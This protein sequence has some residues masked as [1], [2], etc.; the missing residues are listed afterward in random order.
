[1]GQNIIGHF[2]SQ[3][4]DT[5]CQGNLH[6][7]KSINAKMVKIEIEKDILSFPKSPRSPSN[8]KNWVSYELHKLGNFWEMYEISIEQICDFGLLGL[9]FEIQMCSWHV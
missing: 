9:S 8:D 2:K 1:M 4:K 7:D 3:Q 6:Q 5:F